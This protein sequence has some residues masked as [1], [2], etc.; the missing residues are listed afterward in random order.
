[1]RS[2]TI[3]G[4]L[5]LVVSTTGLVA[6]AQTL[7]TPSDD[8]L[9]E[10]IAYR[11][12]TDDLLR[13]YALAADVEGG[14]V[15]LSGTVATPAQKT[16]AERLA[17]ING[18]KRIQNI[19]DVDPDVERRLAGRLSSG[20]SKTGQPIDD[21][22]IT[23]KVMWFFVRDR[24]LDGS[25]IEVYTRD[26]VVTLGGTV[27][28]EPARARAVSLAMRTDGVRRV[29]DELRVAEQSQLF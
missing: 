10:R 2:T 15:R 18:V 13:R 28:A 9:E 8:V 27:D 21:G 11:L 5:A 22:W 17:Q 7:T 29:I 6:S 25:E 26:G 20:L 24:L 3:A 23:S 4:C 1:M 14:F 19:I 12:E 16:S